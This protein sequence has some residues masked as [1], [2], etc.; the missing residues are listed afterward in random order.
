MSN[1]F[2]ANVHAVQSVYASLRHVCDVF[3]DPVP[4]L[5][6]PLP[7]SPRIGIARRR[8]EQLMVLLYAGNTSDDISVNAEPERDG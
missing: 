4:L 3:R 8:A 6:K 5:P 1:H 7:N 2:T